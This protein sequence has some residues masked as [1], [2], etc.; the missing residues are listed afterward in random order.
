CSGR[1]SSRAWGMDKARRTQGRRADAPPRCARPCPTRVRTH[2]GVP[3][4]ASKG[5]RS[6][7]FFHRPRETLADPVDEAVF[8]E[9]VVRVGRRRHLHEARL[10][11]A[12]RAA[13]FDGGLQA[14]RRGLRPVFEALLLVD[15][16]HRAMEL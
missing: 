14:Q 10:E 1:S 15:L 4:G 6:S 11:A 16:P 3:E 9:V 5:W 2:T 12:R 7:D 13:A 8:A